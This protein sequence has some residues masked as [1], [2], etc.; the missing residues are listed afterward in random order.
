MAVRLAAGVVGVQCQ[1]PMPRLAERVTIEFCSQDVGGL[2]LAGPVRQLYR[3]QTREG[4]FLG[5]TVRVDAVAD[6]PGP[7]QALGRRRAAVVGC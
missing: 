7:M 1:A 2:S 5:F 3:L 4:E 6:L